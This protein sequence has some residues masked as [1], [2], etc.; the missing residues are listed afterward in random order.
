MADLYSVIMSRRRVVHK[1]RLRIGRRAPVGAG[2]FGPRKERFC[3]VLSVKPAHHRCLSRLRPGLAALLVLAGSAVVHAETAGEPAPPA[4]APAAEAWPEWLASEALPD[5]SR[6]GAGLLP[7]HRVWLAA[8]VR[9]FST[10]SL[11]YPNDGHRHTGL[12]LSGVYGI[13]DH[14]QARIETR[15]EAG[16]NRF[17][18]PERLRA[19]GDTRLS[20]RHVWTVRDDLDLGVEPSLWILAGIPNQSG[21]LDGLTPG[22]HHVGR[23]RI[24]A[25][26]FRL[27][28]AAGA[29][30]DRSGEVLPGEPTLAEAAIYSVGTRPR[31]DLMVRPELLAGPAVAWLELQNHWPLGGRPRVDAP[32]LLTLHP[33]AA[34]RSPWGVAVH[35]GA[36]IAVQAPRIRGVP[37]REP[38]SVQLGLSYDFDGAEAWYRIAQWLNPQPA[39]VSVGIIDAF[40]G[41]DLSDAEIILD[42]G[43]RQI[44]DRGGLSWVGFA[45]EATWVAR[46]PD[47]ATVTGAVVL[48][49]GRRSEWR[50]EMTPV[51]GWLTGHASAPGTA[52]VRIEMAGPEA[53]TLEVRGG[54]RSSL[55]PGHYAGYAT[56]PGAVSRTVEAVIAVGQTV[57]WPDLNLAAPR[58]PRPEPEKRSEPVDTAEV[59][60]QRRELAGVIDEIMRQ[61]PRS[62]PDEPAT[63]RPPETVERRLRLDDSGARIEGQSLASFALGSIELDAEARARIA[64]LARTITRDPR[65]RS[66]I[67]EGSTDDIGDQ[68]VNTRIAMGRALAVYRALVEDGVP[69]SILG[70][71]ISFFARAPDQLS[72]RE[73]EG[74]RQVRIRILRD[75]APVQGGSR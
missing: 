56:A 35:A 52:P 31:I 18:V 10:T 5:Q 75:E 22:A 34:I 45:R 66:V 25:E 62:K 4:A 44:V 43:D 9:N 51:R 65:V 21:I 33:G 12:L 28:W 15:L 63:P 55:A 61:P 32:G 67:I 36:M 59:E 68:D 20:T 60:R 37:L 41:R 16:R 2:R 50:V 70:L 74:E 73:R 19:F 6:L 17:V 71:K 8:G 46:A 49:G 47:Y 53:V 26:R 38:W 7:R 13:S 29:T 39:I 58:R 42:T 11:L 64:A 24:M 48:Q 30:W 72:P 54:F 23:W 14:M 69:E 1:Q 40:T 57:T 3:R 27:Q